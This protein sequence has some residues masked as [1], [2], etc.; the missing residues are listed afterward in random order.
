MFVSNKI[1]RFLSWEIALQYNEAKR[2]KWFCNGE[3]SVC[4]T[5]HLMS[6]LITD[7]I[8]IILFINQQVANATEPE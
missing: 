3:V 1:G 2:L 6:C 8:I 4:S 5:L 7:I